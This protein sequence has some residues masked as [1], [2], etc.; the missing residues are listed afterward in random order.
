M[1]HNDELEEQKSL[2]NLEQLC[3]NPAIREC[4]SARL[5]ND[6]EI[7]SDEAYMKRIDETLASWRTY[8]AETWR[9]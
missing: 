7:D 8:P 5:S 9:F 2:D 6:G 3:A 1:P 4:M